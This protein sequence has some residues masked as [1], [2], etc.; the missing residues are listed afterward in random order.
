MWTW[1]RAHRAHAPSVIVLGW[2]CA[3]RAPR[4]PVPALSHPRHFFKGIYSDLSPCFW[5]PGSDPWQPVASLPSLCHCPFCCTGCV[6]SWVSPWVLGTQSRCLFCLSQW[7]RDGEHL[8]GGFPSADLGSSAVL[9]D[10][11]TVGRRI[12]HSLSAPL[13]SPGNN[14]SK[15]PFAGNRVN[16]VLI[17][18]A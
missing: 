18:I 12:F 17:C 13:L 15:V 16:Q 2:W 1:N 7:K 6:A 10:N 14:S 4:P 3:Y 11:R 9:K 8:K 5:V